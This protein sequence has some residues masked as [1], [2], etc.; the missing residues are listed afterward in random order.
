[1]KKLFCTSFAL[2]ATAILFSGF[3]GVTDKVVTKDVTVPTVTVSEI[4]IPTPGCSHT[5]P[6]CPLSKMI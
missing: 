5:P 3:T 2:F 6:D 1:M 4:P